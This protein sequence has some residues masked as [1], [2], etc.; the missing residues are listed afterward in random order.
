MDETHQYTG[1]RIERRG[2]LCAVLTR[3]WAGT[4]YVYQ[5]RCR[6]EPS[7]HTVARYE[8]AFNWPSLA[9]RIRNLESRGLD[10]SVSQAALAVWYP[11]QVPKDVDLNDLGL[12]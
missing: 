7:L 9:Q 10:V 2:N 11:P 8:D 1:F 12:L 5:Y 4:D 3:A 6:G